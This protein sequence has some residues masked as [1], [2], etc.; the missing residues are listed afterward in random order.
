M[1]GLAFWV[2]RR[3][4]DIVV[5]AK[6]PHHKDGSETHD[7]D[8]HEKRRDLG[9]TSERQDRRDADDEHGDPEPEELPAAGDVVIVVTDLVEEIGL[10]PLHLMSVCLLAFSHRH[11]P[12][13]ATRHQEIDLAH[14]LRRWQR[15]A[16]AVRDAHRTAQHGRE[17]TL[18]DG[19]V[20]VTFERRDHVVDDLRIDDLYLAVLFSAPWHG[21]SRV[22]AASRIRL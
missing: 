19:L 22:P 3:A 16:V 20:A 10:S 12:L 1:I 9:V 14:V 6:T 7:I 5:A 18:V 4:R 13:G 15:S 17:L 8:S 21:F 11:D 2:W